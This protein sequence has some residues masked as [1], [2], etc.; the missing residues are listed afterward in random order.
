MGAASSGGSDNQVSGAE[1]VASQGK[2]L[3]V[4]TYSSRQTTKVN[5]QIAEQNRKNRKSRAGLFDRSLAGKI[6][7]GITNSKFVQDNNYKRR[8]AF[9]KKTGKLNCQVFDLKSL[10]S[11]LL[12]PIVTGKQI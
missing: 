6:A 9:A 10:W 2:G 11:T 4:S 5:K 8:V 1:A 12:A 3:K 7:T